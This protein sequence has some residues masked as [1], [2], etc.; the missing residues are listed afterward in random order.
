L[1]TQT[2]S[3]SLSFALLPP[4]GEIFGSWPQ[5]I[6]PRAPRMIYSFYRPG[7]RDRRPTAAM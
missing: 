2:L 4:A 1:D 5:S 3:L 6:L 7:S